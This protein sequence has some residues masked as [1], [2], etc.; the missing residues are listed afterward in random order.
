MVTGDLH[1]LWNRVYCLDA[2]FKEGERGGGGGPGGQEH[3]SFL[4]TPFIKRE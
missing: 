4:G 3:P 1:Y 2:T